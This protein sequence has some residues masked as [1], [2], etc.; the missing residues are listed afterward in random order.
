MVRRMTIRIA[1]TCLASLTLSAAALSEPAPEGHAP[2]EEFVE[3]YGDV[4]RIPERFPELVGGET[5]SGLKGE[6]RDWALGVESTWRERF[7]PV[8]IADAPAVRNALAGEIADAHELLDDARRDGLVAT[9]Q[10]FLELR[11]EAKPDAFMRWVGAS[12]SYEWALVGTANNWPGVFRYYF[13][14][15]PS[16]WDTTE[17]YAAPLWSLL[18]DEGGHRFANVGTGAKGVNISVRETRDGT[19]LGEA[20]NTAGMT[21]REHRD[22]WW[23]CTG[24]TYALELVRP[25]PSLESYAAD[26][27]AVLGAECNA[28]VELA[29]GQVVG[30]FVA[31]YHHD[32][33]EEWIVDSVIFTRVRGSHVFF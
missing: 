23:P 2:S 28:I 3:T 20:E 16:E 31:L 26:R 30:V 25:A 7:D 8:A 27:D 21:D 13:A 5:H 10:T 29:N 1:A 32:E 15:E 9:V 6:V 11:S 19:L 22:Y 17:R 24:R 33:R 14:Y 4:V 18:L 12:D